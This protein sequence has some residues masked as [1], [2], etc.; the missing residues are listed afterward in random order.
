MPALHRLF[1]RK[2]F[3][4][5]VYDAVFGTLVRVVSRA[6]AFFETRGLDAGADGVAAGTRLGGRLSA[7]LQ[8]G[9]LNVYVGTTALF[10]AAVCFWVGTR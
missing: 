10:V 8:M 4:D 3:V 7:S 6:S 1:V 2:W 5:E 9:R